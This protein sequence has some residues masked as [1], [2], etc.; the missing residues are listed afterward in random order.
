MDAEAQ[1]AWQQ[2]RNAVAA[3]LMVSTVHFDRNLAKR[4]MLWPDLLT[5]LDE[6]TRLENQGIEEHGWP[7]WRIWG[8]ASDGSPA[9]IVI[10]L[11]DNG[12]VR[13]ITIHWEE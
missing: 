5:I 4:G 12:W 6:P 10:A 3:D 1:S 7:K 2:T 11:Q 8:N 13:L 9:A